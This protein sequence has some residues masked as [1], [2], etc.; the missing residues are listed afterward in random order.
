MPAGS[1]RAR[2][3]GR[4]SVTEKC[5]SRL[6]LQRRAFDLFPGAGDGGGVGLTGRHT[7]VA[8]GVVVA[9]DRGDG[10]RGGGVV[11]Q[12]AG[13]ARLVLVGGFRRTAGAAGLRAAFLEARVSL[14]D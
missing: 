5:S 12:A 13:E 7:A 9:G 14:A 10:G 1:W 6:P 4:S 3:T 2:G 11:G 8:R